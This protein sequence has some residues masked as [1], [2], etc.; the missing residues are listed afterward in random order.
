VAATVSRERG[1]PASRGWH[2]SGRARKQRADREVGERD[3][4]RD[5]IDPRK[6]ASAQRGATAGMALGPKAGAVP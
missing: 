6:L 1:E 3:G 5:R 2:R 4:S